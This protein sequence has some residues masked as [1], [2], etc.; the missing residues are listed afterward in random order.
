MGV[1]NRYQNLEGNSPCLQNIVVLSI[2][3][4]LESDASK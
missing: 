4:F 1:R 2:K 3:T